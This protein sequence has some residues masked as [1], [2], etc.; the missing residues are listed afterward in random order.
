MMAAAQAK[1]A[2][3]NGAAARHDKS[4]EIMGAKF[5]AGMEVG[6]GDAVKHKRSTADGNDDDSSID[7]Y[8]YSDYSDYEVTE[9]RRKRSIIFKNIW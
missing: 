5:K 7:D 1:E 8:S 6:F 3:D 2:F 9:K 4:I